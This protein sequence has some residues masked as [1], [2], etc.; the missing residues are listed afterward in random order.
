MQATPPPGD[1]D[2]PLRIGLFVSDFPIISETFVTTLAADL[3]AAGHDLRV[4]ARDRA[5]QSLGPMHDQ[6][7]AAGLLDRLTRS[8]ET[9]GRLPLA[10]VLRLARAQ[11]RHA[12]TL[13]ALW[14]LDRVVPRRTMAVTR[15]LAALDP[16]DIVH[17]QFATLGQTAQRHR[18]Y[19]TLRTRALVVHMRGYDITSYVRDNG[20]DTY[21]TLFQQAE[22]FVANCAY[23]RQVALDLGCPAERC[24]VIGSPIDVDRF[25]PPPEGRSRAADAPLRLVAVGRLV[26]K[27]GFDDAIAATAEL[28]ARNIP[29]Q[30]DILGEGPHRPV[31]EAAIAA[32]NLQDH[33]TL[34]GVATQAQ[35]IAALHR[36]DIGL[37]PS[38]TAAAGDQDAPVNTLKEKMATGLP[39]IATRHGG[40]P[41]LVIDGTNGCLV[42]EHAPGAIAAAIVDLL[43][44]RDCWPALGAAGRRKV[45]EEYSRKII[46]NRT[47]NA[48]AQALDVSKSHHRGPIT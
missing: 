16:F 42:P 28:R 24:V 47:L 41:E 8:D 45:I 29:V 22:M 39:V 10:T 6:V 1:G 21:A 2:D 37:A 7:A 14:S 25:A 27:K 23:F 20:A 9:A 3:L 38:V 33:V 5:G 11:P 36:A 13:A 48:Y 17:A 26:E 35:I 32:Q 34:H 44:R 19:G 15:H 46:L 43:G 40:I 18:G 31:L 4:M 30:L 12:A